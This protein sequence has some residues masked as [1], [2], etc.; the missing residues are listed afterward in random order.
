[1][2]TFADPIGIVQLVDEAR[3]DRFCF[4]VRSDRRDKKTQGNR[5]PREI[6]AIVSDARGFFAYRQQAGSLELEE[7]KKG[8][9]PAPG[10]G[11]RLPPS[12]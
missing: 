6:A 11:A 5:S 12:E 4:R 9:D 3:S 2:H 1:V 7:K 8:I 10:H